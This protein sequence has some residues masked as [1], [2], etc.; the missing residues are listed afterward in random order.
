VAIVGVYGA[1]VLFIFG[2]RIRKYSVDLLIVPFI[3]PNSIHRGPIKVA[4]KENVIIILNPRV[5]LY[6]SPLKD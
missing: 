5:R 1:R 2:F 3:A 6:G 4:K